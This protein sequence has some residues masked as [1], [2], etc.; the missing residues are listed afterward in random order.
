M[1]DR[2]ARRFGAL[3]PTQRVVLGSLFFA[4]LI[5]AIF[6][7]VVLP[8]LLNNGP[9]AAEVDGSLPGQ[10]TRNTALHVQLAIDNTGDRV[11]NPL[12]LQVSAG[13]GADVQSV[14]FLGVD[15]VPVRNGSACGGRLTTQETI[16]VDVVIVPHQ[17]GPLAVSFQV[18]SGDQAVSRPLSGTITV[19]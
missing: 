19:R 7:T 10:A 13:P 9:L 4:L 16:S 5:V 15:N 17:S 14:T 2:L 1:R 12:C 3:S 18:A 8:L 11:I 6:A